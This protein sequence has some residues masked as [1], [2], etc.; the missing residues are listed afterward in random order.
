MKLFWND[1]RLSR[2]KRV[3]DNPQHR[4]TLAHKY[5]PSPLLLLM[6]LM[7]VH[8][9]SRRRSPGCISVGRRSTRASD[10]AAT[11]GRRFTRPRPAPTPASCTTTA[12]AAA[13]DA[14]DIPPYLVRGIRA[15]PPTAAC[16]YD[17]RAGG[18]ANSGAGACAVGS[19]R[20]SG[21]ESGCGGVLSRGG[22]HFLPFLRDG[23]RHAGLKM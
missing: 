5:G 18:L 7:L 14:H 9:Q 15:L 1:S 3:V 8:C 21:H 13:T 6:L 23:N 16:K 20:C 2:P 17:I 4:R 19:S 11:A 10:A 22:A 12:A